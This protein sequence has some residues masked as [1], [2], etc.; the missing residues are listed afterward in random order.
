[1]AAPIEQWRQL[2][3]E[4]LSRRVDVSEFCNLVK[5]LSKRAPLPEA[6][7]VDVILESRSVTNG[8]Y[9][10]LI[11]SYVDALT[12]FGKLKTATVLNGL[13]KH[14]SIGDQTLSADAKEKTSKLSTLMSDT[15]IVQ[16]TIVPL[17]SPNL[18]ITI[19]D[20]TSIF[21]VASEWI[22]SLVRLHSSSIAENQQ[23][24][25][26][27]NSPDVLAL[28][29]SLG[30]LFIALSAT[31]K[32]LDALSS[33]IL[34]GFKIPLGQ[35][36]TTYLSSSAVISV[37]LRTRLDG[38]QK[39][40]QLY[41]EPPSKEI[42]QMMDGMNM[43]T[44]QFEASVIDGP[45]INSRAG[46][47]VYINAMLIGR[48]LVDDNMLLNYLSNRYG[49]HY[50]MLVQELITAT[51]DVLSNAMYRNESSRNMFVFRSFLVNKLP[52]FL[53]S[54]AA[55]SIQPIPMEICIGH[56]LNRVDPNAFPSFSQMFEMQGNTVLSD[57]RQEFLFSC[58][59]HRLIPE[60]SIERLLGENPMQT[61]PVGGRYVK[62]D[63]ATQIH[64]NQERADQLISEI[65]S[66]EGNA[67]AIVAAVTDVIHS[68][69]NQR[70]T[71][72]LKGIC[73]S[74]SRRPQVLDVMLLFRSFKNILQPICSLLDAWKWDED[75]GEN[76]P[77]YDEFSNILLLVLAFKYRY[78]LNQYDLG[79]SDNQSFVLKLLDRGSTS[80]KLDDLS[81]TQNKNLGAWISALFIAE[82]ISEETM[83]S[84]SPQE[85]YLLVATLFSQTLG[86][87]ELG[88]LEL[89]TLKG[90]FEYLLEPFLLPSLVF[91]LSWL[92][93]YIWESENNPTIPL[94]V[95]Y[96]LVKPNSISGEAEAVHRTVLNI[97]ARCLEEQLKDV[98]AR[99]PARSDIKPI[100][101]VLE[102]YLSFQRNGSSRRSELD[103]WTSHAGGL[104]GSIRNTF[105]GLV[106]WSASADINMS[107]HSYTHRQILTGIR[108]LTASRI[109]PVLIDELKSQ[110]ESGTLDL[111]LDVAATLICSP[112]PE[113]F[114]M[115]QAM[116]HPVD[117]S[118]EALPQ[119]PILTLRDVLILQHQT[120]PK[121]SEKDPSRA[122]IIVRLTRRVNSLLAPPTHVDNLDV[123][124]IMEDINLD[125]ATH[126]PMNLGEGDDTGNGGGSLVGASNENIDQILNDAVAGA[127]DG[128]GLGLGLG[129]NVDTTGMDTSLEDMFDVANMENPELLTDLDMEGMF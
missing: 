35:A 85:F 108:L 101:D 54:M 116:Y 52:P 20:V 74:I 117:P 43:N 5:L 1:M 86:A 91:A 113:A 13:R 102:P 29:E 90:G 92:G 98:R 122:E 121:L 77:M 55:T 53:A 49:G 89:D 23:T 15:R 7:L 127:N 97:S 80:L 119:C 110:A 59:L 124:N 115:E 104:S 96:A 16:D 87:C 106:L 67:G 3:R 70:E 32:G 57:V 114:A 25:G 12:K 50:E 65:E 21:T 45:V 51:F 46:L 36:L 68:L 39:A 47:Y 26:L 118:K 83:S 103:S 88:K 56:A 30:I 111:A 72:T 22:L 24:V 82:G 60:S 2:L 14:S 33:D 84:C 17:S 40:Y 4:C 34:Q 27:L 100:L 79:I 109:L 99:H 11:P 112:V 42:D 120:V 75:Q 62:E 66:M 123:S 126:N 6:A 95:L 64:S 125:A 37:N 44:L 81:E 93:N 129:G 8:Q 10:P 38:L 105:H 69:C 128:S 31:E 18:S 19:H 107:P 58:A 63:I 9:D 71:V 61:L 48:P 73:N 78:D 76:Q 41:G 28:F 94:K